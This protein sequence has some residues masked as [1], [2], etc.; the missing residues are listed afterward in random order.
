MDVNTVT[1][2]RRFSYSQLSLF[3]KCP[4]AYWRRY[5]LRQEEKPAY[6]LLAGS[7]GHK[8]LQADNEALIRGLHA[9][10]AGALVDLA[11]AHFEANYNLDDDP[12][13]AVD[14]LVG[15]LRKPFTSYARKR[16]IEVAP[17]AAE[18]RVETELC[19]HPFVAIID[20]EWGSAL[21]DYKF[22]GRKKAER[23]INGDPQLAIY[24]D[25]TGKAPCFIQ[26]VKGKD[27]L[28][29]AAPELTPRRK[30]FMRGWVEST[31]NAILLAEKNNTWG[32]C[33]PTSFWCGEDCA[34]YFQCAGQEITDA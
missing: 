13:S 33:L 1:P 26:F 31:I 4:L 20:V 2:V 12:K 19:G 15:D 21:A 22:V 24:A 27:D 28:V 32:Q 5:V 3:S 30:Q 16:P 6:N 8:A 29:V 11:V 9:H 25:I 17:E 23:E 18:R 14:A 10:D 34:F 7:A